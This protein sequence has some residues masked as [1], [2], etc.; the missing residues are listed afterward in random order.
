MH[1]VESL[2]AAS[3]RFGPQ[4]AREKR[5]LLA[6]VR[7]SLPLS[8]TRLATLRGLLGFMLAHPDDA[9]VLRDARALSGDLPPAEPVRHAFAL[10]N[11]SRLSSELPGA[12][13]IDW[14][15][16]EQGSA[17]HDLLAACVSPCEE[18]ALDDIYS[19]FQDWFAE[20]RPPGCRNDLEHLLAL[21]R[22]ARVDEHA[23]GALHDHSEIALS[24]TGPATDAVSRPE[25]RVAFQRGDVDRS[26]FDLRAV[27]R[28]PFPEG[29]LARGGQAE[30][31]VALKALCARALEIYPLI[32]ANPDDVLVADC[33]RGIRFVLAGVLPERRSPLESL[34]FFLVLKNG[35]PLGYGPAGVFLGSC[36][37]G[38]NIFPEFRGCEVR[39]IYAQFMRLLHH[40]A[41]V[42]RFLLTGY[43]M[44]QGN[45]AAIATGA[46][47]FYRKLGFRATD[48]E[49]EE[50]AQSEERRMAAEPG[51]RSDRRMLHRLKYGEAVLDLSGGRREPIE[52]ARIGF[53]LSRWIGQ[54]HHGD[55]RRAE[56]LSA[57]RVAR[58]LGRDTG[59]RA[60]PALAPLLCMIPD[61]DSWSARERRAMGRLLDAKDGPSEA[62]SALG[63]KEHPRL[64]EA[65]RRIAERE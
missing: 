33:G 14:E 58:W 19:S 46:F 29:A 10:A 3:R 8:R 61:L 26:A 41:G 22:G 4:A 34:F 28:R 1:P 54:E 13:D 59:G 64:G 62:A 25:P 49:I 42:E 27:I 47:W 56:R 23:L 20:C 16:S 38:I 7:A 2:Q 21:L 48:P 50:L 35:I 36:E 39:R 15:A 52:L 45:P 44:G 11:A 5:A 63:F 37:L 31:D 30:L 55:R 53:A 17:M 51:Y 9:A 57:R 60:L 65:L 40:V 18:L 32:W 24:Y 12:L 43:A 6:R